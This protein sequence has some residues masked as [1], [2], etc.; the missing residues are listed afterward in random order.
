MKKYKNYRLMARRQR[1]K[2]GEFGWWLVCWY[3]TINEAMKGLERKKQNTDYKI[4]DDLDGATVHFQKGEKISKAIHA[5]YWSGNRWAIIEGT[6]IPRANYNE[7]ITKVH[8]LARIEKRAYRI[9]ND[10]DI[11]ISV[12]IQWLTGKES[13]AYNVNRSLTTPPAGI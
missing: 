9:V 11:V 1:R 12:T 13:D 10:N 8:L 6:T 3:E 7:L 4:I 2:K 5:E